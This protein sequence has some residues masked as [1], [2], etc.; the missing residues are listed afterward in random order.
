MGCNCNGATKSAAAAASTTSWGIKLPNG[1]KVGDYPTQS[2]AEI[3]I[4][5][6]YAGRGTAYKK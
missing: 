3:A 4:M 6:T 2:H 1:T 5:S